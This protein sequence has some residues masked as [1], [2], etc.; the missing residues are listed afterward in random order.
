MVF[1][2]ASTAALNAKSVEACLAGYSETPLSNSN[3]EKRGGKHASDPLSIK[4]REFLAATT[5][6]NSALII[7]LYNIAA[8]LCPKAQACTLKAID[9]TL[10]SSTLRSI[11]NNDPH[12]LETFRAKQSGLFNLSFFKLADN[13][14]ISVLYRNDITAFQLFITNHL[15]HELYISS[16]VKL[17]STDFRSFLSFQQRKVKPLSGT[18]IQR[19]LSAIRGYY[20]YLERRWGVKNEALRLIKGPKVNHTIPKP[21]S[22]SGYL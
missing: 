9:F 7:F 10:R 19:Q 2:S 1:S 6:L 21:L 16:L 13:L 3:S 22:I 20:K 12:S 17:K 5:S 11:S 14:R 15:G 18:S 8:E 4:T